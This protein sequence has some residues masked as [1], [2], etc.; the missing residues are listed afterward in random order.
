MTE[1]SQPQQHKAESTIVDKRPDETKNDS[2][3]SISQG[4]IMDTI[5]NAATVVTDEAKALFGAATSLA[6]AEASSTQKSSNT[7]GKS[8]AETA[9]VGV[10]LP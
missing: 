4:S 3:K 6:P 2:S 5:S 1:P 10:S 8:I 7:D 9:E